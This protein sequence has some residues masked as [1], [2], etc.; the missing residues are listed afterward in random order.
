MKILIPAY[1]PDKKVLN[2]VLQL[3]KRTQDEIVIVDDGSGNAFQDIFNAAE[4]MG[5]TV[6][7]HKKNRGKG[8]A[9]KTGLRYIKEQGE[10]AGVVCADCDGQHSAEDILKIA[11]VTKDKGT[12][13][14]LGSRQFKGESSLAQ[15]GGKYNY[16]DHVF[17]CY[18][19]QDSGHP[20]RPAGISGQDVW[21]AAAGSRPTF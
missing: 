21:M 13:I 2:L 19:V 7:H 1:E 10:K 17:F 12:H 6:L 18:G 3:Q 9:L 5:C 4:I 20:N 8:I 16:Q 15:P 11:V 14:T